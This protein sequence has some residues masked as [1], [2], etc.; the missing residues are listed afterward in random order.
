[1]ETMI[2]QAE[3]IAI[4]PQHESQVHRWKPKPARGFSVLANTEYETIE[5]GQV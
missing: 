4:W 2:A 3:F 1:L 5:E